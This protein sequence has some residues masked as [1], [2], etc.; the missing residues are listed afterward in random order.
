[1]VI[2][3]LTTDTKRPKPKPKPDIYKCGK[4]GERKAVSQCVH[5]CV[6]ENEQA[7]ATI[8]KRAQNIR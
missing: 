4:R 3:R 2:E 6:S 7:N 5:V 8:E 1:M